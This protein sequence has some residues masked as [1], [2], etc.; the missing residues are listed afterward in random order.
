MNFL[1]TAF[2]FGLAGSLH[3]VGMCSPLIIAVTGSGKNVGRKLLY[4]GGRVMVYAVYGAMVAAIG[5]AFHWTA[6]QNELS[7][8]AGLVILTFAL[9]GLTTIRIPLVTPAILRLSSYLKSRFSLFL[10]RRNNLALLTMGALNGMLPCGLTYLALTYCMALI[11]PVE[12]AMFMMSFGL[13]TMGVMFGFT[14]LISRW[15][16]HHRINMQRVATMI[17]LVMGTL[18]AGRSIIHY[19][20]GPTPGPLGHFVDAICR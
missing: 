14:A 16:Q 12:G 20:P 3:C 4:N 2:I 6:Y 1:A 7:L 10:Q 5:T 8:L 17:L 11:G 19:M 9:A 18:L 15:V 13:G